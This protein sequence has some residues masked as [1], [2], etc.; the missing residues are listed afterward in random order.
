MEEER[1]RLLDRARR[2]EAADGACARLLRTQ[3]PKN[4]FIFLLSAQN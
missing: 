3:P 4:F 2:N 1:E